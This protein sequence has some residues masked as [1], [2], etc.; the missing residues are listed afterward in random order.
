MK[1]TPDGIP[2]LIS[3]VY[4]RVVPGRKVEGDMRLEIFTGDYW[5]PVPMALVAYMTEFFY[6]NE[7]LL[8]PPSKGFKGGEKFFEYLRQSVTDGY[9]VAQAEL[10]RERAAK[11]A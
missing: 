5:H 11:N 8:Y 2:H 6:V 9:E 10:E 1:F 4:I 7:Q 3:G